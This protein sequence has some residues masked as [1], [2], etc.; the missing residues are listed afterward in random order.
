MCSVNICLCLAETGLNFSSSQRQGADMK[1]LYQN[2]DT[3]FSCAQNIYTSVISKWPEKCSREGEVKGRG[4]SQRLWGL[5]N[6]QRFDTGFKITMPLCPVQKGVYCP[7]EK[8]EGVYNSQRGEGKVGC[9]GS[10]VILIAQEGSSQRL[11]GLYKGK[12]GSDDWD[13]VRLER[14]LAKLP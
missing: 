10:G 7:G 4:A 12:G 9:R 11:W 13:S 5:Y 8:R 2:K 1:L 3:A 6:L 14:S